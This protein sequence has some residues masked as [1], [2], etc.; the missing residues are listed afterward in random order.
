SSKSVC[1][2]VLLKVLEGWHSIAVGNA[3]CRQRP[4]RATQASGG[5][6]AALAR[7]EHRQQSRCASPR[8]GACKGGAPG[9]SNF[10]IA[11]PYTEW[12]VLGAI[13]V[14]VPGELKWD[15]ANLRF[16]NSQEATDLVKPAFRKGWEISLS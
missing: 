3:Y 11:G 16:T 1:G 10:R 6:P 2:K 12:L 8:L 14:R 13:A 9:C 7:G 15:A 5:I 4:R